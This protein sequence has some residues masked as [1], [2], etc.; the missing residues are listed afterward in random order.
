MSPQ[1]QNIF[2]KLI[3]LMDQNSSNQNIQN[4]TTDKD[5]TTHHQPTVA[6]TPMTIPPKGTSSTRSAKGTTSGWNH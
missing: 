5:P 3:I 2:N 4:T 1:M 6:E